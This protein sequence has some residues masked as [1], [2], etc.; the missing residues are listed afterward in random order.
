VPSYPVAF[1]L[2]RL[3]CQ[4]NQQ[5]QADLACCT[6]TNV[7]NIA[8]FSLLLALLWLPLRVIDFFKVRPSDSA[9]RGGD[10]RAGEGGKDVRT[11]DK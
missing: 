4:I 9:E 7:A 6:L 2:V 1:T 10:S 5:R 3:G 11:A 8:V